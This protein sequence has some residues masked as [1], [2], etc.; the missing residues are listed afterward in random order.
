MR[1]SRIWDIC[2]SSVPVLRC[3]FVFVLL[4]SSRLQSNTILRDRH[5]L[6][7]NLSSKLLVSLPQRDSR[8]YPYTLHFTSVQGIDGEFPEA[9]SL[10]LPRIRGYEQN[11]GL[12]R[13]IQRYVTF[14]VLWQWR[15]RSC[16][17]ILMDEMS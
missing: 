10:S 1:D 14:Q 9:I 4:P 12:W 8:F 11:N 2:S 5:R 3:Y 6:L 7:E 16:M 13:T 17:E 15:R